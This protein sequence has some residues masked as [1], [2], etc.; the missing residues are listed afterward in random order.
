MV[1]RD[2]LSRQFAPPLLRR[3]AGLAAFSHTV[4]LAVHTRAVLTVVYNDGSFLI[5]VIG[6]YTW[7]FAT[8]NTKIVTQNV[9][10]RAEAALNAAVGVVALA[11]IGVLARGLHWVAAGPVHFTVVA[12]HRTHFLVPPFGTTP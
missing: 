7:T 10:F 1:R 4:K 12:L 3:T 6:K 9:T 8:G 5:S 2:A 11:E